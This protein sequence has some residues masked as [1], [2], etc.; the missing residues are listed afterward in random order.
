MIGVYLIICWLL[1]APVMDGLIFPELIYYQFV[2]GLPVWVYIVYLVA[3][4]VISLYTF[5]EMRVINEEDS[6]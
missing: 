1:M 4:A 5:Y 2:G 6:Y 3:G